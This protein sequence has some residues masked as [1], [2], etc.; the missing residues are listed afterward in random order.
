MTSASH[1]EVVPMTERARAELAAERFD[2]E[3]EI[4]LADLHHFHSRDV[5][6]FDEHE[7]ALWR[8][9]EWRHEEHAGHYGWWWKTGGEWFPYREPV[10]PYPKVVMTAPGPTAVM[11]TP[12][13]R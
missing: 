12:D 10:Y 4:A 3:H 9:G 6:N 13:E 1:L 2:R 8:A 7:L 5:R 11:P